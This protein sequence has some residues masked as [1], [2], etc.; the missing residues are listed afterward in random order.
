MVML[1]EILFPIYKLGSYV[2]IKK[3]PIGPIY[4]IT[5]YKRYI[6]DDISIPE[7]T[8]ARRRLII[9][10]Q[11][12]KVP[13]YKFRGTLFFLRDMLKE[14][15]NTLFI[16]STGKMLR[17]QKGSKRFKVVCE[18]VNTREKCPEGNLLVGICNF[19]GLVRVPYNS[20]N[21]TAKYASI[22]YSDNGPM[23]YDLVEEY[24]EPYKR[25]I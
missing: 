4:I 18:Q 8:L 17:Y 5:K 14:K 22:L 24:H 16:D 20:Y 19:P 15:S 12:L 21:L 10:S 9:G 1:N 25:G 7:E 6:L 2:E 11:K 3:N 13:L 23:L